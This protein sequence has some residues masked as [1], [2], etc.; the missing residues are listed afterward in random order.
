MCRAQGGL[1]KVR[2]SAQQ[3]LWVLQGGQLVQKVEE[4]KLLLVEHEQRGG[5]NSDPV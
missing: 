5:S 2:I 1:E 4:S 3:D